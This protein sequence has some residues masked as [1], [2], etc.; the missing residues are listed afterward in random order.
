MGSDAGV[1]RDLEALARGAWGGRRHPAAQGFILRPESLPPTDTNAGR[2]EV[3]RRYYSHARAWAPGWEVPFAVPRVHVTPWMDAAG[4]Y[5]ADAHGYL[6]IHV[7][8]EYSAHENACRVVLAHEACHHILDV[9]G[10]RAPTR[11]AH[12]RLTDLAMYVCGLGEIVN[13][14]VRSLL[15]AGGGWAQVHLGYLTPEEHALA[16]D[17]VCRVQGL[18]ATPSLQGT[19]PRR[20]P[21]ASLL[22]RVFGRLLRRHAEDPAGTRPSRPDPPVG[23]AFRNSTEV[24]RGKLLATLG[25]DEARL[26]RLVAYERRR[27]P[28]RTESEALEAVWDQLQQDRR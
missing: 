9:S 18:S 24:L 20:P 23:P 28:G 17:W 6:S 8:P 7:A 11:D 19:E 26:T 2:E 15:V 25:H 27:Q 16:C 21:R 14:G 13:R 22:G 5:E 4:A 10:V 1:L 3:L 12:E